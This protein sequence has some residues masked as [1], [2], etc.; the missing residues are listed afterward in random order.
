MPHSNF[1]QIRDWFWGLF[2]RKVSPCAIPYFLFTVDDHPL[3]FRLERD[4][5]RD[6]AEII[7]LNRHI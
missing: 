5:G 6:L 2:T 4:E 7:F 3:N 1:I